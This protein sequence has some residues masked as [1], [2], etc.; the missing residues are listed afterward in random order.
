MFHD[1]QK[2]NPT[3]PTKLRHFSPVMF[4]VLAMMGIFI[5]GACAPAE[6]ALPTIAELPTTIPQGVPPTTVPTLDPALMNNDPTPTREG[7]SAPANDAP[8]NTVAPTVDASGSGQGALNLNDE[9]PP[10]LGTG[11]VAAFSGGYSGTLSTTGS[12]EC[13]NDALII[14][15]DTGDSDRIVMRVVTSAR[16]GVYNLR[17]N[18]PL[19]TQTGTALYVSADDVRYEQDVD[20]ILVLDALNLSDGGT[21]AGTFE[22]SATAGSENI[23]IA[24]EF[25]IPANLAINCA[26]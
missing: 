3:M 6:E 2:A 7:D 9:I 18:V 1:Y 14:A 20:G 10:L 21:I 22:F 8:T 17:D 4:L 24:G 5:L 23:I 25:N 16:V 11:F 13:G 12:I 26:G 15:S 19:N